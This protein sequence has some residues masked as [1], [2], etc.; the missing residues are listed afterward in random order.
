MNT[1][2]QEWIGRTEQASDVISPSL[3]TRYAATLG[4][5]PAC[6]P[7]AIHW[8]VCTGTPPTS[9]LGVDGHPPKGGFLPPIPLPRRMWAGSEISF[10][11]PLTAGDQIE[12][13][14]TIMSA[15][16][17]QGSTGPLVFVK[18]RHVLTVRGQDCVNEIQTIVY[19]E[20]PH[21]AVRLPDADGFDA[22]MH[23]TVK[24]VQPG[25]A[26]LFRY[27]ALTFNAHRIHYDAGYAIHTEGYPA[28][29]V[30]APLS[31]SL[32]L[33]FAAQQLGPERITGFVF[34]AIAPAF[35]GQQL[36]LALECADPRADTIRRWIIF[37]GDGRKVMAGSITLG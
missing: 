10:L 29:V 31:A 19:R 20:M 25:E 27:S 18:I 22:P 24:T 30:Q 17:K 1:L 13:S 5:D 36:H 28:L 8:C 15:E 9:E 26:F 16:L 12:R 33:D 7:L 37:G 34:Q 14:S 32:M 11:H 6:I 3:L 2:W 4:S 35:V 23:Y 21:S